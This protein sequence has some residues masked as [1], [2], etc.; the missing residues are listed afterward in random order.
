M[1]G[2]K[3]Q[4]APR[5]YSV[6]ATVS[7]QVE[8]GI[9]V[10]R[11][12]WRDGVL[13]RALVVHLGTNGAFT[14]DQCRRMWGAVGPDRRLLLVTVLVPRSWQAGNNRV[15]RRCAQRFDN[16]WSI[17]WRR[18][19]VGHPKAVGSHGYHLTPDRARAYARLIDGAVDGSPAG[20]R[21]S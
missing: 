8:D 2:A 21:Q 1:L 9:A 3:P 20:A 6:D 17:D 12:K 7:H 5:G 4:L 14:S 19:V 16:V 18:Y 13:R 11:P 10:L 15:I